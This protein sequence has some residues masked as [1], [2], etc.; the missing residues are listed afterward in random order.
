MCW[1]LTIHRYQLPEC[2]FVEEDRFEYQHLCI[3]GPRLHRFPIT[4]K[5]RDPQAIAL[6]ESKPVAI[7]ALHAV[8]IAH[9]NYRSAARSSLGERRLMIKTTR[10]A[11]RNRLAPVPVQPLTKTIAHVNKNNKT[12]VHKMVNLRANL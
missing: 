3:E 2:A 5:N 4:G 1:S 10:A 9:Y 11:A 8:N 6:I 12:R 7:G